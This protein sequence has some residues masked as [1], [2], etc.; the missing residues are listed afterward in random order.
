MT[1]I[2][3]KLKKTYSIKIS[4]NIVGIWAVLETQ[5]VT[6]L[7]LLCCYGNRAGSKPIISKLF[8]VVEN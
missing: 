4:Q 6:S 3:F 8:N 7:L 1:E 5:T 2:L